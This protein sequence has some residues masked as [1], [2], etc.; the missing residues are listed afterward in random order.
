M[1]RE[2][3][4]CADYIHL[5]IPPYIDTIDV[6]DRDRVQVIYNPIVPPSQVADVVGQSG[7]KRFINV[8][9]IHFAQ[10]AQDV[11][12]AAFAEIASL[13]PD[14]DL[15]CVGNA[16]SDEEGKRFQGLISSLGLEGR[17]FWNGGREHH[18]LYEELGASQIFV[19]PSWFEGSPISLAEGLA[20]G[21]PAI[22]FERCEGTNQLIIGGA[23]GLLAPG[24]GDPRTLARAML[25]LAN[26]P[27]L[28]MEYSENALK[29]KEERAKPKL[30]GQWIELME[31]AAS[32]GNPRLSRLGTGELRYDEAIA[33]RLAGDR[34]LPDVKAISVPGK[35]SK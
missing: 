11:L 1:R 35:E 22:G 14:W 31:R 4:A 25:Q 5:L 33:A 19:L 30:L 9:R 3:F 18:R 2:A 24:I 15:V 8:A 12:L 7:R 32:I 6:D 27:R 10:K 26:S 34:L 28:R 20:H 17:V 29:V 13:I 21:L 16:H 23:N